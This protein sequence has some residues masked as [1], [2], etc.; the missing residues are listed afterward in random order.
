MI[1]N[2]INTLDLPLIVVG[3]GMAPSWNLFAPSMFRAVR[4]YSLVYRLA[5]PAQVNT[6]EP[7]RTYICPAMVGPSAGLLGAALLPR[8][9]N[10]N[11]KS[12]NASLKPAMI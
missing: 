6:R 9:A 11:G 8:L 2:L 5:T 7:D 12:T 10:V 3:G 1:A 4:D